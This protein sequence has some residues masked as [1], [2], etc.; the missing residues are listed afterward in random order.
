M[1]N[2]TYDNFYKEKLSLCFN[3][4]LQLG[5]WYKTTRLH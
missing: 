1:E 5:Y 3:N 2:N 4:S